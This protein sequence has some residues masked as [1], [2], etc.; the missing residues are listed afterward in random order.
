MLTVRIP[1]LITDISATGATVTRCFTTFF[2]FVF[3][4]SHFIANPH[5]CFCYLLQGQSRHHSVVSR[6]WSGIEA[7][8]TIASP[9]GQSF[10]SDHL[11]WCF[12][13]LVAMPKAKDKTPNRQGHLGHYTPKPSRYCNSSPSP[14]LWSPTHEP[15]SQG[16]HSNMNSD[17]SDDYTTTLE[18][19]V[20]ALES[21]ITNRQRPDPQHGTGDTI[22]Q[23]A[24]IDTDDL[25]TSANPA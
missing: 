6:H 24:P 15:L 5:P 3:R 17:S 16:E 8:P 11:C 7:M 19:P 20:K 13:T 14:S 23:P 22:I 9:S 2:N 25:P 4:G 18:A 1:I 12:H 21:L 10:V